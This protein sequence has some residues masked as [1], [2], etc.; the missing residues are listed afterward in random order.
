MWL[1]KKGKLIPREWMH[2]F[3][4]KNIDGKTLKEVIIDSSAPVPTEWQDIDK[5]N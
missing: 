4:I 5:M 3:D 1:V 2:S